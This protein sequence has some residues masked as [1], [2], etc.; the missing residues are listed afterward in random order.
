MNE[1]QVKKSNISQWLLC[2]SKVPN[3]WETFFEYELP[4]YV[5][6]LYAIDKKIKSLLENLSVLADGEE[7]LWAGDKLQRVHAIRK[8]IGVYAV[9][10]VSKVIVTPSF[11]R[12]LW[13]RYSK[14]YRTGQTTYRS[15]WEW[16]D[17][18][19]ERT[20]TDRDT[21]LIVSLSDEG[22][23]YLNKIDKEVST[24]TLL[25]S[26]YDSVTV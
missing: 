25:S 22:I 12:A 6:R 15:G 21:C 3:E 8:A 11:E 5:N 4:E 2:T 19:G 17:Y 16:M 23:E 20:V 26:S 18:F 13:V 10:S 9:P 24:M 14:E 1:L 7:L